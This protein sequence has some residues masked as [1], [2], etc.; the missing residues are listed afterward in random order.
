MKNVFIFLADGFEETE[1]IATTDILLRAEFNVKTVS[2]SSVKTVGG[3]HNITVLADCLLS[4]TD[5]SDADC[6]IL[7]GGMPGAANLDQNSDVKRILSEHYKQGKLLAAICAAPLVLGR[8]K[9]L[10][11]RDAVCY[12]GF[13]K[14]LE[15]ASLIKNKVAYSKNIITAKGPGCVFEFGLKII[16][17][18]KDKSCAEK[19]ADGLIW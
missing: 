4:E 7:P 5:F 18:L 13:E 3:T 15:G 16:E 14:Y 17:L 9:F 11:G 2:I 12:P 6:L 10:V 19:V 1:A 8:L